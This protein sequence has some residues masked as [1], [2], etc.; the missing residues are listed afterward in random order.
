MAKIKVTL[1]K[2]TIGQVESVKATVKNW[3]AA[4]KLIPRSLKF[5]P[6]TE[7]FI[8]LA[9]DAALPEKFTRFTNDDVAEAFKKLPYFLQMFFKT[10]LLFNRQK[11]KV[12]KSFSEL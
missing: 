11:P 9:D 6:E 10:K 3:I 12:L 2:S 5:Y 1:V 4:A 8:L 7:D